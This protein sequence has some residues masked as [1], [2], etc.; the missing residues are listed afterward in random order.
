MAEIEDRGLSVDE[1]GKYLFSHPNPSSSGNVPSWHMMKVD[2]II[3]L[4]VI[5][6]V[7]SGPRPGYKRGDSR[8]ASHLS[9]V[10][11][12]AKGSR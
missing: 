3:G 9:P 2:K 4:T 12:A 1:I 11:S 5:Q 8:W 6:S 10:L 7:F